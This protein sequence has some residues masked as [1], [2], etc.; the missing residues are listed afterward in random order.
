MYTGFAPD[1]TVVLMLDGEG[2][3]Y[4]HTN[5]AGEEFEV[6]DQFE[7][8]DTIYLV[9]TWPTGEFVAVS[10]LNLEDDPYENAHVFSIDD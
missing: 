10:M 2:N 9:T 1:A 3:G 7:F 4:Y 6:G 5:P 8:M